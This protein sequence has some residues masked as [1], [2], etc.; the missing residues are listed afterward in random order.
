MN[1]PLKYRL[2]IIVLLGVLPTLAVT[3]FS[4][5]KTK[6]LRMSQMA[7]N[8]RFII[9][10]F[11]YSVAE[12]LSIEDEAILKIISERY[13]ANSM[14]KHVSIF[15]HEGV[16]IVKKGEEIQVENT[17]KRD[18]WATDTRMFFTTPI[19]FQGDTL[20]HVL[21]VMTLSHVHKEIRDNTKFNV[22]LSLIF[23]LIALTACYSIA[24]TIVS[25]LGKITQAASKITSGELD[26]DLPEFEG[27]GEIP[28]LS[29]S[30]RL[31][32]DKLKNLIENL[33]G[34]VA[35]RTEELRKKNEDI[36]S[37]M[38]NLPEGILTVVEGNKI[39][40]EY[41]KHLEIILRTDKIAGEDFI[42]LL[43]ENAEM[44]S[45]LKDQIEQV[46]YNSIGE[47]IFSY[48]FNSHILPSSYKETLPDGSTN[49]F[50]LI[51]APMLDE[52]ENIEKI[53]I[54]L[55]D[56]TESQK[57][58]AE[59]SEQQRELDM[60]GEILQVSAD[61][62]QKFASTGEGFLDANESLIKE[63]LEKDA[64]VLSQLFVNMHTLKGNA[65]TFGLNSMTS[66]VHEVENE[67]DDL[68]KDPD[69]EWEPE[70]LLESLQKARDA[71]NEYIKI[72]EGKLG[73]NSVDSDQST[74]DIFRIVEYLKQIDPDDHGALR[75]AVSRATASLQAIGG[76]RLETVLKDI[77]DSLSSLANELEKP[78]P[79]VII[80]SKDIYIQTHAFDLLTGCLVH[81]FR[82]SMDHGIEK[83]DVRQAKGKAPAGTIQLDADI[84]D[85]RARFTYKDDGQGL[86]VTAIQKKALEH[87]IVEEGRILRPDDV[88]KVIFSSGFSTAE[89]VTEISG[90]GVGLD[91]VRRLI[92]GRGGDIYLNV[93]GHSD[94]EQFH[95][96]ET[97]LELPLAMIIQV[98]E[99]AVI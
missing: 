75:S 73:R 91:A 88:S 83:P 69:K 32:R 8:G 26:T 1:G 12:P 20:G 58:Q 41:S 16:I 54:C 7:D 68:R 55:R 22:S 53:L 24:T 89:E 25:K 13:L 43:F 35:L 47:P 36:Q 71:L 79:T 92:R 64:E 93:T 33:E 3:I 15:D 44:G 28:I 27:S 66:Q 57:L 5:Y 30:L 17:D 59:A 29:R 48:E 87:G 85:S 78:E 39:H 4:V 18:M 51:W 74:A 97:V 94:D 45:D 77:T 38:K 52:K 63:T 80:R 60:I 31:M 6:D 81:M 23:V 62:F 67:L 50:E 9:T 61:T 10:N 84:R 46:I 95:F 42:K 14:V 49:F 82:N 11:A 21:I 37:I 40:P 98:D 90:R 19:V 99:K 72:S 56:V 96:F 2:Y 34:I 70:K 65:R 86:S 76:M